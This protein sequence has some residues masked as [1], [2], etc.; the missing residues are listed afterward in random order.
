[1]SYSFAIKQKLQTLPSEPGVYLMKDKSCQVIYVGKAK[2]LKNRVRSYFQADSGLSPKTKALV[3]EIDDFSV[4]VVTSEVEALLLERNLIRHHKPKYNVLL[5]DDKEYPYVRVDLTTQWPRFSKVRRRKEDQATYL[6][7]FPSPTSLQRTLEVMYKIFP[8]IRCSDYEFQHAKRP[9][10]YY[11]MKRCLGP[12]SL[13]VDPNVYKQMIGDAI[14]FLQNK[15]KKVTREI[16]KKMQ[17]ASDQ[18]NYEIA[19][20]YRDQLEALK[21]LEQDQ[22]V[23]S[24]EVKEADV[25]GIYKHDSS[26]SVTILTIRKR[27]LIASDSF[28]FETKV[29]SVTEALQSIIMQYYS[30]REVAKLVLLPIAI[31]EQEILLKALSADHA[32]ITIP[33][34]GSKKKLIDLATRNAYQHYQ[35]QLRNSKYLNTQL[36]ILMKDLNLPRLPERMECI[37]ISNFQETAIVASNVC[38]ISGKPAKNHYRRYK[39]SSVGEGSNDYA[40]ISQVVDRRCQRAINE[41]DCPDLLIIDGGKGQLGA[42]LE[43]KK[44]YPGLDFK[45]VGLAKS[46]VIKSGTTLDPV[47]TDERVFLPDRTDP[48]ILEEGS[49]SYRL[50]TSIRDEAHRFAVKF[51]RKKRAEIRQSST[52]EK[53]SGVGPTLRKRLLLHFGSLAAIEQASLEDLKKVKGISQKLAETIQ[54]ALNPSIS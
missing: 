46:R 35:E 10:N 1:M 40:A 5:R 30:S 19:A 12:C 42:A 37:D 28:D 48:L 17:L 23:V 18:E 31:G 24:K 29:Q 14:L 50:L 41:D 25:F 22:Q 7:P 54:S 34:M 11:H 47:H 20:L 15:N 6:G 16:Y 9:C 36:E 27:Q 32:Q 45:I 4:I 26:L 49:S 33:K 43:A 21:T 39:I 44:N 51:H 2:R 53:I 52:L 8:L 3:S 38:F 13:P